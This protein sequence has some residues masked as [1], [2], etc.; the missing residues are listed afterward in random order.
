MPA[1][2]LALV[3]LPV[4]AVVPAAEP[5]AALAASGLAVVPADAAFLSATLRAREQ[6]DRFVKSNAYATLRA[7]PALK[8]ALDSFEEQRSMPGSPVSMID[9]FLQL[10]ENAEAAEL[11]TDMVATDTF[12]YG[13]PSCAAFAE[14]VRKLSAVMQTVGG[15]QP[16]A[17]IPDEELQRFESDPE[18]EAA[19]RRAARRM[20]CQVDAELSR[21]AVIQ[22]LLVQTLVDNADLVVMPDVVWGFKTTKREAAKAQLARLE[23]LAKMAADQ[24]ADLPNAVARKQVAGGDFVVLTVPGESLPWGLIEQACAEE[25]GDVEG[26]ADVFAKLRKLDL[27]LAVGVVGDRVILSFGDSTEHL[28]KLAAGP[29]KRL[30]AQP[31]FAPVVAHADKPLTGVSY[32]SAAM[33]KALSQGPED[34]KQQFAMIERTLADAGVDE[35]VFDDLEVLVEKFVAAIVKRLPEPD[36]WTSVAFLTDSG[37]E[38]E[39]WNWSRNQP[40][41]GTRRLDLLE[42]AGG[43]PLAV[44]VSRL[45]SDPQLVDD[46]SDLV[47]GLWSMFETHALPV[48]EAEGQDDATEFAEQFA[49][50]AERFAGIVRDKLM[51]ALADGQVGLVI[52]GKSRTK[53]P[54]QNLPGSA[55]ALPLPEPAIV[56]PLDDAKLFREGLSD[57]FALGDD[58]VAALRRLDPD[59]V[60]AGYEV[61]DPEKTK[62]ESGTVW[63]FPLRSSGIDE[64]VRPAIGVGEDVA[65]LSLAPK[66]AA[67]LLGATRLETGAQLSTFEE[68]LASAAAIDVAGIVDALQPWVVYLTRYG[69]VRDRDGDV[70]ADDE[71]GADDETE[72]ARDAL[73]A[74][75]VVLEVAKC[76]RA[77]VAETAVRDGAHVTHWKNIIRDLPKKP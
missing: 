63:S 33:M 8:R 40:L 73:Q 52:D 4:A 66:Q 28:A 74:V 64:Q 37:Y 15:L 31:A 43:A 70:D 41:D 10:P 55:E 50:L 24:N 76:L 14:L 25:A 47:R 21:E 7:V 35:E 17:R 13:E 30:L 9:T 1:T 61:P 67:R 18:T 22:R 38:G 53:K 36:A 45:R 49:P 72:Q 46:V 42:H 68:P 23:A 20:L 62:A 60:P 56:L 27:C 75:G 2:L 58:A 34:V 5:P 26:F 57:L 16:E 29:G 71:L 3:M 77:A 39:V 19:V 32:L 69:C 6:Y 59:A 54:Q 51:P 12:V 11:L 65:V 44:A 48:F